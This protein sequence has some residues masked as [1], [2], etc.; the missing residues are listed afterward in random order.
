MN[1]PTSKASIVSISLATLLS[2]CLVTL[3]SADSIFTWQTAPIALLGL[4]LVTGPLWVNALLGF[5][6]TSARSQRL[7]TLGAVLFSVFAVGWGLCLFKLSP[8]PQSP[9]GLLWTGVYSLPLMLPTWFMAF[10][11]SRS[12][13]TLR[14]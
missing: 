7:L 9:I 10:M 4:L 2:F 12:D 13:T 5:I 11:R 6:F 8:S 14:C 3:A 1:T